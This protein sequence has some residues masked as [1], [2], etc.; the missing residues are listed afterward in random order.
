[1]VQAT[2][3]KETLLFWLGGLLLFITFLV[4]LKSILL[5]FVV[6]IIT[7]Y[8]LDPVADKL[9]TWGLSRTIATLTIV[10]T[11]FLLVITL[12]AL[13]APVMYD[14]LVALAKRIP[15]YSKYFQEQ[16]LPQVTDYIGHIDAESL[17]KAKNALSNTSGA[18]FS[19]ITK[20][21]AGVLQS[22]LAIVNL[23]M[24]IFVTPIVTFYFLHDW[25][26]IIAKI[27]SW[28]PPAY[29]PTIRGQA[30]LM[31]RALAGYIR[32][33][34]NVCLI[35]ATFYAIGLS[36]AGLEFGLFIGL[37]TGILTF[38]P[39]VGIMF[40]LVIGLMVAFFQY[41]DVLHVGLVAGV[42]AIGQFIEG[43]FITPKLVGDKVGLHPVWI[44][45]GM[46]AGAA[47][48]GF[49]GILLAVPVTAVIAVLVR[50]ALSKYLKSRFYTNGATL[51]DAE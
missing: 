19:F 46:L 2:R 35:L 42:F 36:L 18:I 28:L 43:N 11:F 17:D 24:L 48:F 49:I 12:T 21:I 8:F 45:F 40:G 1:M 25:D 51:I 3:W 5:P 13:L 31:D 14:Q 20:F 7:G 10:V 39:Y 15:E 41:G 34:T 6:A 23:L 29:A 4:L 38:I 44:I 22:T 30:K 9:E 50:F 33:Q 26:T 16:I 37:C 27:N 47:L 32:G